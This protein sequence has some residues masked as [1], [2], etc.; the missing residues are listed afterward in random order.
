M[1]YANGTQRRWNKR[2]KTDS[3]LC[4]ELNVASKQKKIDD[5]KEEEVEKIKHNRKKKRKW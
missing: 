1:K 4:L 3:I 5:E 2:K